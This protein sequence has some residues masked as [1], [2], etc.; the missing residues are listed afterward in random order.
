[1]KKFAY[2][3]LAIIAMSSLVSCE[4]VPPGHKGVE[5]SWGGETNLNMVYPEGMNSGFH[6][7]WDE[8][9]AYDVREKT[10]VQK[11][12]FNDVN[13]MVT[14]VEVSID[15]NLDPDK[16]NLLH[17]QISDIDAKIEKTLKSACKE[18]IPQYSAAELNKTKRQEAEEKLA[19]I[20]SEE[21]P[22][23]YVLFARVQMTDVD[24][25]KKVAATAEETAVQIERN[26]LAKKKEAEKV[27]LASAL[28]A[29]SKGKFEAAEYDAKRK[30]LLSQP[31]ML[32]LKELEI[33]MEWARR[34]QS[35]YG[36]NNVFGSET[37]IVRGLR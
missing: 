24:I 10:L 35:P 4:S 7:V 18:V 34:G 30:E 32:K 15:Y 19:K 37:A 20:L 21:L 13:N 26:E 8:M 12:E 23:F 33:Q 9:V 17:V 29:E 36:N 16:V 31:E 5:V 6:W 25:P 11:Y 1:M 27:A 22:E 2:A 28:I 3:L 14:P